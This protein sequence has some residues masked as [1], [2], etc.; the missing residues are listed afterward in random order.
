[1]S[2]YT[3]F[4]RGADVREGKC[5]APKK[6]DFFNFMH[7]SHG[8]NHFHI[9]PLYHRHYLQSP[10]QS[11]YH[12]LLVLTGVHLKTTGIHCLCTFYCIYTQSAPSRLGGQ[13][14]CQIIAVHLISSIHVPLGCWYPFLVQNIF[15][16]HIF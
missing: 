10:R 8:F 9:H 6:I 15:S 16:I 1:M 13:T 5:P 12:N 11:N 2:S 3:I 7:Y 14:S 4:H